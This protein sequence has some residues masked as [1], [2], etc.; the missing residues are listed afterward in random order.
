MKY[1]KNGIKFNDVNF[2]VIYINAYNP[3]PDTDDD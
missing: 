3:L 1:N 2:L